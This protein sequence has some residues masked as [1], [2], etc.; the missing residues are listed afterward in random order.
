MQLKPSEKGKDC[1]SNLL[2]QCLKQYTMWLCTMW[3]VFEEHETTFW[4]QS[5]KNETNGY[6]ERQ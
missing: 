3:K 6:R 4:H 1:I 5:N 2:S